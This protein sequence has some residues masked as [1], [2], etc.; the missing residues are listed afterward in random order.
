MLKSTK[1]ANI[2]LFILIGLV[3]IFMA[4]WIFTKEELSDGTT[5]VP[6][7][8]KLFGVGSTKTAGKISEVKGNP[9]EESEKP[10]EGGI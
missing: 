6:I 5:T 10:K 4:A 8:K 9:V 3:V 2:L 1:T 7:N